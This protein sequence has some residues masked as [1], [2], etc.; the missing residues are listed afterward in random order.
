MDYFS[1]FDISAAGMQ[2][3][4]TRL[5]V[6]ALNL[7]NLNTTRDI[8]GGV[9]RPLEVIVGQPGNT[10]FGAMVTGHA[11]HLLGPKVLGVRPLAVDPRM[12]YAPA[13]PDANSDGL[14]AYP[15][16]NP[17]SEM[18]DLLEATR[19]Y[20]ANVRAVNAVKT[21]ALRALEIGE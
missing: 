6:S 17:V 9:Y 1:A 11:R 14:V 4:K 15:S 21:M 3:Q 10:K 5:D 19:A 8:D 16:V 13:H 18:V 12:V 7:A 2:V 20:E